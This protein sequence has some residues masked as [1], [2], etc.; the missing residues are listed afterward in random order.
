M[1]KKLLGVHEVPVGAEIRIKQNSATDESGYKFIMADSN[2]KLMMDSVTGGA[3]R[4]S[5]LKADAVVTAKIA[6]DAVT[7]DKLANTSVTA[8]SYG[9]ATA[10]P[11]FTVDAQG[12][13]TAAGDTTIA[14]P[15]SQITDF[16]EA[17]EDVVAGQIVT[18]GSHSG[19]SATYDDAN[20]GAIAVSYTH[21]TLPTKA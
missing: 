20:D 16:D 7:A 14:I 10:I 11:T 6:D 18:N 19:V 5:D 13:L 3:I 1:S 2:G 9:S 12:R 21:L 8:G 4:E 17:V 15:H